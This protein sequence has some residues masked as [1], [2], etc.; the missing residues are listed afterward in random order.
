MEGL[1]ND[2]T[3]LLAALCGFLLLVAIIRH[4]AA[5][6]VMPAESWL[7]LA[8]V[9]YGL[10]SP[11]TTALPDVRLAPELVLG[12][13]VPVLVF[14]EGRHL[15]IT[16]LM[17]SASPVL[18]LVLLSIPLGILLIGL[19]GAWLVDI[20]YLHGVLFGAAVA[21]TDPAAVVH[22]LNRFPLPERLRLLLHGESIFNDAITIVLFTTLATVV[23]Y[24]A[25]LHLGRMAVET[26][27]G[28]LLA[29]PVGLLLGWLAGRLVRHWQEQNR[30]PG[31]TLTLALPV[32]AF[33]L[34]ERILHASGIIAVL[35]AALA[36]SHSRWTRS[37]GKRELYD[38]FWQYL[39]NFGASV[40]FF[41]L[42]AAMAPQVFAL[43]WSLGLI[44]LLLLTSRAVLVY[45]SGWLLRLQGVSLP[46][47]WRHILML[48][49]LRGAVPAAL[50]LMLPLDYAYRDELLVMVF[51]LVAYS[52]LVHPLLLQWYLKRHPVPELPGAAV[53]AATPP[54]HA[55]A[56]VSPALAQRL[57]QSAWGAA[58]LAGV[59]AGIVFLILEMVMIPLFLG[60]GPWVP[61]RM[62]AAIGLGPEVLP[63]PASFAIDVALAAM[64]VHF[65]LSLVY[66]WM[67]APLVEN[68]ALLKG[69][70]LGA[71]FGL[72]IYLVNFYFFTIL[73]PW[74]TEARNWITI[75]A[76][77][78]FGG[79]LAGSY[80]LL[81]R[82]E[83][84]P[85]A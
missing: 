41:A 76:H 56:G 12:L 23:I 26:L 43:H 36:F 22:I 3:I 82:R 61:V 69:V 37:P 14:A 70:L 55:M 18:L 75:F 4:Y 45:G 73:F 34:S 66:A 24:E 81:R 29:V 9:G 79:V 68:S 39:G 51:S 35:F 30:F 57:A 58:A 85:G 13:L 44:I 77:L 1:G 74:F 53:P 21:A 38:E 15:P 59:A 40:L 2:Y 28:M 17:R 27:R 6:T 60:M 71:L 31:L 46:G 7:L 62:I 49:G 48:G 52:M 33:L 20:P 47:S 83:R 67:F 5:G 72:V 25:D 80:L 84:T 11:Q 42:G 19:P 10:V 50:V 8:G 16:L 54:V 63:P 64:V 78:V 65:T 32:A